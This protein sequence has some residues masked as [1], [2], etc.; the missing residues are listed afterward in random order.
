MMGRMMGRGNASAS[1][2]L[3]SLGLSAEDGGE[4]FGSNV[5][6]ILSE[7]KDLMPVVSGD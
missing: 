3:I 6:V 7:A 5:I 2:M 4:D 1:N